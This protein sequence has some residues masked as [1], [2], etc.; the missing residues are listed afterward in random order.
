MM[1]AAIG[2]SIT[3]ERQEHTEGTGLLEAGAAQGLAKSE[4]RRHY[5]RRRLQLLPAVEA[6]LQQQLEA[7]LHSLR[8]Q[9]RIGPGGGRI[10][11]YWPLTGEPDLRPVL[12]GMAD[13]E[14]ALPAVSSGRLEYRPWK[15]GEALQADACGIPAPPGPALAADALALLLIPALAIDRGGIRLGYG[16]GWYD[17]LR[18]Q[19]AWRR[20]VALGVL[21][22]GCC[23]EALPRD[24]WDIPLDGW[25]SE[26]G[27][28]WRQPPP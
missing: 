8:A 26:Q 23:T 7:L 22:A 10:G 12:S 16:G 3:Q 18:S 15:P 24:P 6:R 1:P 5:R 9:G 17:R 13:L 4:L 20:P 21:P 25:L 11:L 2:S 27:C 19:E 28:Q 14:L